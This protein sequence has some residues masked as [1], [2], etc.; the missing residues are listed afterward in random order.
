MFKGP[1]L[2]MQIIL[3]IPQHYDYGR[4]TYLPTEFLIAVYGPRGLKL[5]IFST[6]LYR[7]YLNKIIILSQKYFNKL[8]KFR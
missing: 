2:N 4:N 1:A 3:I 8:K 6:T 7:V 5:I